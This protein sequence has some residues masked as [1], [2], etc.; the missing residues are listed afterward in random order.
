MR[1]ES[2]RRSLVDDFFTRRDHAKCRESSPREEVELD[3][4]GG[5][6]LGDVKDFPRSRRGRNRRRK[7]RSRQSCETN[8][9]SGILDRGGRAPMSAA[10]AGC[11]GNR[12][13][14]A[15]IFLRQERRK[16][17]HLDQEHEK[18]NGPGKLQHVANPT[19]PSSS[20]RTPE[21][22]P[23]AT[24]RS[25]GWVFEVSPAPNISLLIIGR[26]EATLQGLSVGLAIECEEWN[27]LSLLLYVHPRTSTAIHRADAAIS[28]LTLAS[29]T[30]E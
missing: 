28:S 17:G 15:A 21:T 7:L 27:L 22:T 1:H 11:A 2:A 6:A 13:F 20:G 3:R 25:E 16:A 5:D 23:A 4:K 19:T 8:L 18:K 14:R 12:A 29:S 10:H 24:R 30:V 26:I 9:K